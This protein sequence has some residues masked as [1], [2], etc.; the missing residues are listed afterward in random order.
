MIKLF[1]SEKNPNVFVIFGNQFITAHSTEI[2]HGI[3]TKINKFK[4]DF[5]LLLHLFRIWVHN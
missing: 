1:C 3:E 2:W 4:V 5:F